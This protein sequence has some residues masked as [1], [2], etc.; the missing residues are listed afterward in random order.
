MGEAGLAFY[1]S[2]FRH[3]QGLPERPAKTLDIYFI[4]V[5]RGVG[6]ATLLVAPSGESM[7]LNAGPSYSALNVF[8][9]LHHAH[10]GQTRRVQPAMLV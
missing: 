3:L 10:T 9:A 7:L 1:S 5:G 6:N 8:E 4:D 2:A